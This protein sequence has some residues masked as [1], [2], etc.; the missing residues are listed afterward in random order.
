MVQLCPQYQANLES[1]TKEPTLFKSTEKGKDTGRILHADDGLLASTASER[2]KFEETFGS[3]VML[4]VSLPLV[5]VGDSIEF[6]KRRYVKTLEGVVVYSNGKYLESLQGTLGSRV[7]PRDSPADNSFLEPD[8]SKELGFEEAKVY[9]ESV[10][11]LLYLAHSRPDVQFAVCILS[12]KMSCPTVMAMKWLCRVVGC[13][14]HTPEVGFLIR[15]IRNGASFSCEGTEE[16]QHKTGVEFKVV[17]ECLTDADWGG[18]KRTRKSRSSMQYFVGGSLVGS[19]VRT[20]KAIALSSA[21][22]EFVAMIGGACEGLYLRDCLEYIGGGEF[23]VDLRSRSD[24]ASARAITQ[25]LGCGRVHHLQAGWL[26]IQA[27]VKR[28]EINVGPIA[29]TTN[30]ADVGT[31][32]LQG[33]RIRE[34]LFTMGAREPS[35][36]PYGQRDKEAAGRRRP[37][38]GPGCVGKR[39][40]C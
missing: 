9:K 10:G 39:L 28:A 21:E 3:H 34:L 12:S 26:W 11:R 18:C 27:Y 32:P 31:K 16:L 8:G 5:N 40:G 7:K 19:A 25:R 36:R 24:S 2:A 35:G 1:Y 17:L 13:L 4:Q 37:G 6:L 29:G 20:Q 15:P 38:L 33:T 14:L 23:T 22:S 30:P